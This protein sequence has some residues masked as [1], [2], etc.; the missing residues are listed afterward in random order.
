MGRTLKVAVLIII[1]ISIGIQFYR[2]D[3][4]EF[5]A[6]TL[7]DFLLY[8]G[9]PKNVKALINNSC[10]DCHSNQ[11]NYVWFDHIAPMS[12]TVDKHINDAKRE[13]NLSEWATMDYRDKRKALSLIATNITE[14]KMPLESYVNL[15][16]DSKLSQTDKKEILKWLFTIEIKN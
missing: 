12:W 4:S 2:P 5:I 10:Y 11:T 9:A 13:L 6:I 1:L 8:E 3:K 14:D 15:H 16:W 7:D